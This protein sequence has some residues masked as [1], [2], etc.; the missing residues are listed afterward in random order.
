[1]SVQALL[2]KTAKFV[3]QRRSMQQNVWLNAN[4]L[5]NNCV[6]LLQARVACKSVSRRASNVKLVYHLMWLP[7]CE[8]FFQAMRGIPRLHHV[9][10]QNTAF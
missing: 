10:C 8:A 7:C 1:M 2:L 5:I 9:S 3:P 4:V 6:C